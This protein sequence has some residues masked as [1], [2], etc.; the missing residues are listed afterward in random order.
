MLWCSCGIGF[1]HVLGA[2]DFEVDIVLV[3]ALGSVCCCHPPVLVQLGGVGCFVV[4]SAGCCYLGLFPFAAFPLVGVGSF[5]QFD[6]VA[7]CSALV[8]SVP[9]C[10]EGLALPRVLVPRHLGSRDQ[11]T[12]LGTI[13]PPSP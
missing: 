11:L 3:A 13:S 6:S 9:E 4:P 1:G 10:L 7:L 2:S 12:Y 8:G 5:V